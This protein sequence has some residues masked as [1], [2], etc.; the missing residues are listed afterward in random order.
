MS[1]DYRDIFFRYIIECTKGFVPENGI[2]PIMQGER[3][4]A[5]KPTMQDEEL[6]NRLYE[7]GMAMRYIGEFETIELRSRY[8]G[9]LV[10]LTQQELMDNFKMTW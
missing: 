8:G 1:V 7:G 5:C 6:K 2:E 9:M 10:S 4:K 3:L